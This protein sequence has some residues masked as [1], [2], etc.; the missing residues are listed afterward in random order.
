MNLLISL[1]NSKLPATFSKSIV[2]IKQ[3]AQSLIKDFQILSVYVW[4]AKKSATDWPRHLCWSWQDSWSTM[5]IGFQI[6]SV[7]KWESK[8]CHL[9]AAISEMQTP[10]EMQRQPED[11]WILPLQYLPKSPSLLRI[12]YSNNPWFIPSSFRPWIH[13]SMYY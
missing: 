11:L 4:A 8:L 12:I 13:I 3:N 6:L 5:W 2:P 10:T 1:W 7:Y 9:W